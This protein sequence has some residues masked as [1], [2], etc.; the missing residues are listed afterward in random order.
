MLNN[1]SK[2]I[3]EC[4]DHA[5]DCRCKAAD[6]TDP[7]LKED[8]LDMERRWLA[9]AQS[10]DFTQRI[11]DFSDEAKRQADKLW[12][13]RSASITPFLRAQAFDPETVE[14]MGKAFATT[15]EALGLSNQ[16]DAMTKLVA[17]RIIELAQ[18]GYKNPTGLHLAAIKEFKSDPQ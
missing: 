18:R 2:Q 7:K 5:E 17:E 11:G 4:L 6:L 1:L 13:Q 15:C 14:A 9:L 12:G 16:D 8:F 3:R 10:Y